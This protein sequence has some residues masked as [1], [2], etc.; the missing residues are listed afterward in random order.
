MVANISTVSGMNESE[1]EL[2]RPHL[3]CHSLRVRNVQQQLRG[4]GSRQGFNE[5]EGRAL[6]YL[7]HNAGKR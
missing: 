6:N 3:H 7:L 2:S 4:D 1:I 5:V